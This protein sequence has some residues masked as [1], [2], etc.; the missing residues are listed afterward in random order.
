[1]Y[2]D[3]NLLTPCTAIQYFTKENATARVSD[4][5]NGPLVFHDVTK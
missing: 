3:S 4:V 2:L 5:A 1:M